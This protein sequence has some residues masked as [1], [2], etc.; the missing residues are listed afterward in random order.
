MSPEPNTGTVGPFVIKS[1][2]E[3]VVRS[4]VL[5]EQFWIYPQ[6]SQ[7]PR[8]LLTEVSQQE[9][10]KYFPIYGDALVSVIGSTENYRLTFANGKLIRVRRTYALLSGLSPVCP[11][12]PKD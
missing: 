12:G 5:A 9:I 1:T 4:A 6:I 2:R 7:E 10:G 11:S 3:N 8:V